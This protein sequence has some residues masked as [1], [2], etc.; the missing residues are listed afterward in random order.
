MGG[1]KRYCVVS[2]QVTVFYIKPPTVNVVT[3]LA[4]HR[5]ERKGELGGGCGRE[6]MQDLPVEMSGPGLAHCQ[7]GQIS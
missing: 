2:I 3:S 7:Q 1:V 6:P 4:P 5:H